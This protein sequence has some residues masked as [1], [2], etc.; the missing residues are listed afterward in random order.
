VIREAFQNCSLQPFIFSKNELCSSRV[1]EYTS[2]TTLSIFFDWQ[3]INIF[4]GAQNLK[5]K[6]IHSPSHPENIRL[7]FALCQVVFAALL[8]F[9]MLTTFR[10]LPNILRA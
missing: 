5:N 3:S 8:L 2:T 4:Y 6:F 10:A 9:E 7:F 1:Q